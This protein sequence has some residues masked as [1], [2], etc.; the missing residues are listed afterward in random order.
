M[1]RVASL[2]LEGY[3]GGACFTG[4]PARGGGGTTRERETVFFLTDNATGLRLKIGQLLRLLALGNMENPGPRGLPVEKWRGSTAAPAP[5]RL[6]N[7]LCART[8]QLARDEQLSLA[9]CSS[10]SLPQAVP[11]KTMAE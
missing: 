7:Q 6:L 8:L 3:R 5:V 10:F 1:R 11:S 4:C 2:L 9:V